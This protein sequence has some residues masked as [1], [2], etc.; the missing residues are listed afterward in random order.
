MKDFLNN[1]SYLVFSFLPTFLLVLCAVTLFSCE[2][3][4]YPVMTTE[5]SVYDL[6]TIETDE[7]QINDICKYLVDNGWVSDDVD[8]E[9]FHYEVTCILQQTQSQFDWVRPSL[10]LAMVAVESRYKP[11]AKSNGGARGL[12]QLI[13]K[14]N[15]HRI[16]K[17]MDPDVPYD[18][19]L[20]YDPLLNIM[21]GLDYIDYILSECDNNETAALM[22]Y[23][24]GPITGYSRYEEG[25]VSTYAKSVINLAD[26]LKDILLT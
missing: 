17:Y 1:N 7:K 11:D 3:K 9:T 21:T 20:F 13:P 8:E 16:I 25:K 19:D 12:F 2:A 18:R 4:A 10:A 14:Y 24:E 6:W 22:W 26:E 5:P 23:N 15:M